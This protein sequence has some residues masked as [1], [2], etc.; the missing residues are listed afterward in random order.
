MYKKLKEANIPI[1]KNEWEEEE[2]VNKKTNVPVAPASSGVQLGP[3]VQPVAFVPY[4]TQ[5]Q[6][7]FQYGGTYDVAK[8]KEDIER[9]YEEEYEEDERIYSAPIEKKVRFVPILLAILS[10]LIVGVMVAGQFVLQNYLAICEG[11]SGY[12]YIF[13]LVDMI[14]AGDIN[15]PD[16]ILPAAVAV[17]ALF[18]IIN[19]L[20]SLIKMQYRGA[21]TMS[22]I[23]LFLMVTFAL[24][25]VLLCLMNELTMNYGLYA[26]VGLSFISLVIISQTYT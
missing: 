22:K 11:I 21:C 24:A 7:L 10:L 15:I 25:V 8:A 1:L 20:S 17:V 5:E 9:E 26:V 14:S 3:I 2:T 19:F 12:K 16:L 6:P 23:S 18:A 4:N 13:N